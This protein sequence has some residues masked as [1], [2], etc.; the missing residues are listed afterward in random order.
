MY[1]GRV[2][3]VEPVQRNILRICFALCFRTSRVLNLI[4]PT[5]GRRLAKSADARFVDEVLA[6]IRSNLSGGLRNPALVS[7]LIRGTI[8]RFGKGP[9]PRLETV[10]HRV[11]PVRLIVLAL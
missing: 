1:I 3:D 2:Y 5:F 7:I 11:L 4:P 6:F 8:G 9:R 10:T